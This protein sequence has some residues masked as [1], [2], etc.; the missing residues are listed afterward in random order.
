LRSARSRPTPPRGSTIGTVVLML[1]VA[2]A[3]QA[4]RFLPP[5]VGARV[6]LVAVLDRAAVASVVVVVVLV[7]LVLAAIAVAA[8]FQRQDEDAAF[9]EEPFLPEPT[10]PSTRGRCPMI[11]LDGLEPEAG[12][13]SLA[14]NLAVLVA[15]EGLIVASDGS[16]RRPRPL[17]LL[18]DGELTEVLG[19]DPGPLERHLDRHSGLVG[20]DLVDVTTRHLSGCEL[21]CVPRGRVA[22]HQL[23]L[24]GMAVAH[25]YD[26]IVVDAAFDDDHLR[27]GVEDVADVLV[28]VTLPSLRSAEAATRLLEGFGRYPRLASTG[29]VVN[30]MR[31]EARAEELAV[32]F[33]HVAA[34][35]YEPLVA[36]ADI[37]GVPW[38]LAPNSSCRRVLIHFAGRLLPGVF[39]DQTHVAAV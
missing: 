6:P 11:G 22:R 37:R 13:S 16:V 28:A 14:F 17:C 26:L 31:G 34:F 32:G 29:L 39:E 38:S 19:L 15:A 12:A 7:L 24:L 2:L 25:H 21:L 30:Q 33:G 3:G 9:E 23:R 4:A 20:D 27:V 35:P 10:A 1:M 36:E 8:R 5:S 18:S